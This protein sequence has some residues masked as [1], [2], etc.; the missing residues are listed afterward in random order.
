VGHYYG[1]KFTAEI[2]PEAG[3][4]LRWIQ[5]SP[6]VGWTTAAAV[7]WH[8]PWV[9]LWACEP[10][11]NYIPYGAPVPRAEEGQRA[12]QE[13]S[14]EGHRWVVQCATCELEEARFFFREILP[15]MITSPVAIE[16][17]ANNPPYVESIT[18]EPEKE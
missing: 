12:R 10:H 18:V 2:T 8:V 14:V 4:V 5:L 9:V 7:W 15:K 13:S 6:A 3:M 17:R 1:V 16:I 11:A